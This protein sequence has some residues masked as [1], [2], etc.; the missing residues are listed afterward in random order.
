MVVLSN[1]CIASIFLFALAST[2]AGL[3][4]WAY[5][6]WRYE[7]ACYIDNMNNGR[8]DKFKEDLGAIERDGFVSG[9]YTTVE[10]SHFIRVTSSAHFQSGCENLVSDQLY[11]QMKEEYFLAR[12]MTRGTPTALGKYTV[13]GLNSMSFDDIVCEYMSGTPEERTSL[14]QTVFTAMYVNPA[15]DSFVGPLLKNF[16]LFGIDATMHA[17]GAPTNMRRTAVSNAIAKC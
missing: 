5:A 2:F 8:L 10:L 1:P 9:M 6:S 17:I 7:S 11:D 15:T 12:N 3:F 13:E 4:G 14:S 16:E